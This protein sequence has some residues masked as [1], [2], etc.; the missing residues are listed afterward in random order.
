MVEIPA[1]VAA[2][3][4]EEVYEIFGGDVAG[5]AGCVGAAAHT[6]DGAVEVADADFVG[7]QGVGDGESLGV[8][9]VQGDGV[10]AESFD[11]LLAAI[12]DLVGFSDADGVAQGNL[13]GAEIKQVGAS[14]QDPLEID[15]AF[16]GAAKYGGEIGAD[17]DAFGA[18]VLAGLSDVFETFGQRT[19]EIVLA[20]GF[21]GGQNDGHVADACLDG[22]LQAF[23]VGDQC[24]VADVVFQAVLDKA[25]CDLVGIGHL[26]DPGGMDEAADFDIFYTGLDESFD[27]RDFFV[28]AEQFRFVLEAITWSY[29]EKV[30]VGCGVDSAQRVTLGKVWEIWEKVE[31]SYRWSRKVKGAIVARE[32]LLVTETNARSW[33]VST[34]LQAMKCWHRLTVSRPDSYAFKP[35]RVV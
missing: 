24:P 10:G 11:G 34:R 19:V 4:M 23:E 2:G 27:Q 6:A 25:A 16:K 9:Q 14:V 33:R 1:G 5:G 17:L 21:G 20:V 29:L 32:A 12:A 26:R 13:K 7:D 30:N 31:C 8:V 22:A 3:R 18:G 28:D 35:A 15:V